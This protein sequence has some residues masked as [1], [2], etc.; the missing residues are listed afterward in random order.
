MTAPFV[1]IRGL[2]VGYAGAARPALQDVDLDIGPGERVAVI[3]ESGSGKST[4]ALALAGLLPPSA[5]VSGRIDWRLPGRAPVPGRDIGLVFQDPSA[6]LDPVM[7]VGAQLAEVVRAHR[8]IGRREA[9]AEAEALLAAVGIPDPPRAARGFPH[10]LSGGQRQ[11]IALAAALAARPSLLVADEATS[12]LDTLVQ[13]GIV[14]LLRRLVQENGTTL[15]AITHDLALAPQLA[16]R[17]IVL[18]E[19]RIV[20]DGPTDTVLAAPRSPYAKALLAAHLDL[21]TLPLVGAG[22][23]G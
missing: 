20:E 18:K 7:R 13:A 3:G 4:L 21:Q 16:D 6:S 1:A 15:V 2:G 19:G 11:R 22:L 23:A 10:R 17:V 8:R 9:A 5:T 12:A 14:A